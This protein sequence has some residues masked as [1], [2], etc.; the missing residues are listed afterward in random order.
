MKEGR[1]QSG[2]KVDKGQNEKTL[3]ISILKSR[4]DSGRQPLSTH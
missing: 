3:I 2:K 1:L 4:V